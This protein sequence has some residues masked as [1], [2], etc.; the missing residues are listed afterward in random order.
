MHIFVTMEMTRWTE[1]FVKILTVDIRGVICM[2]LYSI[3][4][5]IHNVCA[6]NLYDS[7][8]SYDFDGDYILKCCISVPELT[9][10][11]EAL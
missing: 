6:H 11:S 7:L 9:S 4:L 3:L 10:W 1:A 5:Y 8:L 2:H